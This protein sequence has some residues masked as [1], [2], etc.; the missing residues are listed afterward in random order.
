MSVTLERHASTAAV[1]GEW[2]ALA[3]AVG[4]EPFLRPGWIDAWL[5]AFGRGRLAVYAVRRGRELTA[6]APLLASGRKLASPTNWHTPVWGIV[7]ADEESAEELVAGVLAERPRLLSLGFLGAGAEAARR[8]AAQAGYATEER[9]L[10][11]SPTLAIEGD[12]ETYLAGR[13]AKRTKELARQRRKL[14][15]LGEVT[16]EA[17]HG[18][19]RLLEAFA[20]EGSGWKLENG[21]AILSDPAIERFY[22]HVAHWAAARG[23]WWT[24]LLRAGGRPVASELGIES[25]GVLYNLK[26]GYDGELRALAPGLQIARE[27]VAWCFERGLRRFE[28]LGQVEPQKLYWSEDVHERVLLQAF[29]PTPAGRAARAARVR[30]RPLAKA[31]LARVRG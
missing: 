29:A 9:T 27:L 14:E 18:P 15:K 21:T 10:L 5:R 3:D 17:I 23:A 2:D 16:L 4:A 12:F 6:V 26:G 7:A 19:D 28:M 11:R 1:A 31:A 24:F 25:D 22:S 13:S 20:L 8:A 30:G